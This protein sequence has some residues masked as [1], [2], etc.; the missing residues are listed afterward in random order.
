MTMEKWGSIAP[1]MGNS[2]TKLKRTQ[3]Y[4]GKYLIELN[5]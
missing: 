5:E 4:E 3:L 2:D 1:K